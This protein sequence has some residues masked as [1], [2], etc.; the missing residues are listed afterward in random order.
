MQPGHRFWSCTI[1]AILTLAVVA[2]APPGEFGPRHRSL[3]VATPLP[4]PDFAAYVEA[5]KA[6][7]AA[8][9]QALGQPL[10]PTAIHD[11]APFGLTP[12]AR[13]RRAP[14]GRHPRAVLLIHGLG[15]SPYVMRDLGHRFAAACYLVR[16]ILLPGHG[17]VP[18]DL[19]DVDFHQWLAATA[20]GVAS[21]EGA[22]ER[23]FLVGFDAGGTLALHYALFDQPPPDLALGGLVL[24]APALESRATSGPFGA[25]DALA[26]AGPWRA[27]YPDTDPVRYESVTS[28][29]ARQLDRL[30]AD[31]AAQEQPLDL[32]VFM[33]LTAADRTIDADAARAWFCRQLTGPREL[34]W[35]TSDLAP[36]DDCRFVI[37]RASGVPDQI[38]DLSH[39]ALPLA[40]NNRHYGVHGDY[41]SCLHYY[42][43]N[44]PNWLICADRS[45]TPTNSAVRYGEINGWNTDA[46]VV[47]RLTYNPDFDGLVEAILTF[48]DDLE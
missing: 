38:L 16:A 28:N 12:P 9:G 10:D 21:L 7:I 36:V 8:A 15:D 44:S 19:L 29:A 2:C 40:P 34:L 24:L 43:E 31:F 17:T 48:L 20:R 23:V 41:L 39:I 6:H 35:Y 18:G 25:L 33:A 11:R 37:L 45:R 46:H 14:D 13:C 26:P 30:A 42:W 3:G 4:E 1:C 47:R 22:A 5:S 32:P 27:L